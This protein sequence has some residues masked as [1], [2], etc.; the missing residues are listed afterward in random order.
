MRGSVR[1]HGRLVVWALPIV[2]L[3]C[4]LGCI[5]GHPELLSRDNTEGSFRNPVETKR[6]APNL[7]GMMI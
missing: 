7:I 3:G 1:L 2:I 6:R 5:G 4:K